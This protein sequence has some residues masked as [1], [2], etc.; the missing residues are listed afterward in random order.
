MN[1]NIDQEL[2]YEKFSRLKCGALF[3]SM[4]TG[5]TKV[6][7][8]LAKSK[9]EQGKVDFVQ[10]IAPASVLS[11]GNIETERLKWTPDLPVTYT[12]CEGIGS[13]DRI[14]LNNL[15]QVKDHRTFC[16]CDESLYIKNI[17]AKRTR[18]TVEMGEHSAYRMILNGTPVTKN[19][20][21]LWTQM[22]FL[23]PK[24]LNMSFRQFKY[25]FCVYDRNA[26]RRHDRNK[27][28]RYTNIPYLMSLISPYIYQAELD[29][30]VQKVY[31]DRYYYINKSKYEKYKDEI[32]DKYYDS[33][34]DE[35][36][37]YAFAQ[38]LQRWY[39]S[40]PGHQ[41]A[42]Q[43]CIDEI[44]DRV[45]VFVK[46]IENIPADAVRITG[47]TKNRQEILERFRRGDFKALYMT[48]GVGS[49]SLN[50]QFCKNIIFADH[51]WDYAKR[52]QAEGR[53]YRLGSE[54]DVKY[55]DIVCENAGLEELIR[56]CLRGKK[57]LLAM[58]KEGI[59][60]SHKEILQK[61]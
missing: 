45:I 57:G 58:V 19:I 8:S 60:Q 39:T 1:N 13:S 46:Y 26:K 40:Q 22:E 23:S 47:E 48:Y 34:E 24:I 7:L 28:I 55:Y 30:D 51:D 9:Y 5:K 14:Y 29:L 37:F 32:F 38:V 50:L 35:L 56:K 20:L 53:I 3:M 52:V 12:T 41:E 25:T 49:F 59:T 44:N 61:L 21:D 16:I 31:A 2:A 36:Q 33:Y 18:R 17:S 42:V 10:Y 4:G 27:I 15:S 54:E 6:A 43:E 11:L